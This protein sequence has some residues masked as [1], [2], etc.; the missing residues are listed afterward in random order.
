MYGFGAYC[1][2]MLEKDFKWNH[3]KRS[4]HNWRFEIRGIMALATAVYIKLYMLVCICI[5]TNFMNLW[6]WKVRTTGMHI[7][8]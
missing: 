1:R 6:S 8:Q 4:K 3:E 2:E 7:L 5:L